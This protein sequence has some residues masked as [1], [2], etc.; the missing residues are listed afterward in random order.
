MY[1]QAELNFSLFNGKTDVAAKAILAEINNLRV[2]NPA[3]DFSSAWSLDINE[4][5]T[6]WANRALQAAYN[7]DAAISTSVSWMFSSLNKGL[8]RV[9]QVVANATKKPADTNVQALDKSADSNKVDSSTVKTNSLEALAYAQK[10][11]ANADTIA[12]YLAAISYNVATQDRFSG[13][14][15][16]LLEIGFFGGGFKKSPFEDLALQWAKAAVELGIPQTVTNSRLLTRIRQIHH[17]QGL[18]I[19]KAK[20]QGL[21]VNPLQGSISIVE[22]AAYTKAKEVLSALNF[23][24][25]ASSTKTFLLANTTAKEAFTL[26]SNIQ[27]RYPNLVANWN[28]QQWNSIVNKSYEQFIE[29][30]IQNGGTASG[31]MNRL[32]AI[33]GAL[34]DGV[35]QAIHGKSQTF[36]T[37]QQKAQLFNPQVLAQAANTAI[38]L[39]E[40]QVA[41]KEAQNATKYNAAINRIVSSP[42]IQFLW[43][44]LHTIYENIPARQSSY[45]ATWSAWGSLQKMAAFYANKQVNS[46]LD[47]NSAIIVATSELNN[48]FLDAESIIE[49]NKR[50]AILAQSI[51]AQKERERQASQKEVVIGKGTQNE[52]AIKAPLVSIPVTIP[53]PITLPPFAPIPISKTVDSPGPTKKNTPDLESFSTKDETTPLP[54]NKAPAPAIASLIAPMKMNNVVKYGGLAAIAL[55]G[56]NLFKG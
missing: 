2:T 48:A 38:P 20:S 26:A 33:Q 23:T 13:Y 3:L 49:E 45:Y 56:Y 28:P 18:D 11:V 29:S 47:V 40:R 46:S 19:N 14:A 30:Y 12:P 32:Y 31:I 53:A 44:R 36:L 17:S 9:K 22:N 41:E 52:T 8:D 5:F 10:M 27:K 24:E 6:V 54:S 43:N 55:V 34:M 51:I 42:D 21:N 39:T 15:P 37:G 25:N 1:N 7:Q 50:K 16:Y 35:S 4:P